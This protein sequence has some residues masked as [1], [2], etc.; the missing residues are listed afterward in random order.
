MVQ[1]IYGYLHGKDE[2]GKK[3]VFGGFLTFCIKAYILYAV[4]IC[5]SKLVFSNSHNIQITSYPFSSFW[6]KVYFNSTSKIIIEFWEGGDN[7]DNPEK[8][9]ML[10]SSTR[11]FIRVN[12]KQIT[13]KYDI[14]GT[15]TKTVKKI[16]VT[17]CPGT[18]FTTS[19]QSKFFNAF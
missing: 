16:P 8:S 11:K 9:F 3:T 14:F 17:D 15:E 19:Y 6:D 7:P 18:F 1:P 10:D 5:G 2:Y 12:M 13:K 4:I